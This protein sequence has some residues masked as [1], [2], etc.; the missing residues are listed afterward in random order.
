M[1]VETLTPW[2]NAHYELISVIQ[3]NGNHF[4]TMYV[5]EGGQWFLHDGAAN[6]GRA[7]V[8]NKPRKKLTRRSDDPSR[9]YDAYLIYR[10][11]FA[12]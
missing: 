8:H 5:V 2:E 1:E 6:G 12:R 11:V 4:R 7:K 10:A 3:T 9:Y